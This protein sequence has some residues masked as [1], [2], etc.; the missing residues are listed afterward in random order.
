M[1]DCRD[2]K[3]I[4]IR[5][6]LCEDEFMPGINDLK[7]LSTLI[8]QRNIMEGEISKIIDRPAHSG[9][10]GESLRRV[11]SISSW[12]N[13]PRMWVSMGAFHAANWRAR[14]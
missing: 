14:R 6:E 5:D 4:E 8:R 2:P 9:H 11:Y 1:T 3:E 10:I 7:A 12:S 13:Q